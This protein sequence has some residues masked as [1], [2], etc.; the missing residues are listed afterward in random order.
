MKNLFIFALLASAHLNSYSQEALKF[1]KYDCFIS[2]AKKSS[3]IQF[4][5]KVMTFENQEYTQCDVSDITGSYSFKLNCN[6]TSEAGVFIRPKSVYGNPWNV[7]IADS[8][9]G[10]KEA[11][12]YPIH[13]AKSSVKNQ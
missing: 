9:K 13:D 3:I 12:C 2:A 5:G 1:A 10:I 7:T 4:N 8:G 6:S 11:V